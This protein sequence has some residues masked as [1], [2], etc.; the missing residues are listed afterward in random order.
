MNSIFGKRRN[1]YIHP[2]IIRKINAGH[3]RIKTMS[4]AST[5][6]RDFVGKVFFVHNGQMYRPVLIKDNMVGHKL[7][8]FVMTKKICVYKRKKNKKKFR[9]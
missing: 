5:I 3:T 9:K 6:R 1:I 8:E 2:N 7:G 4:R